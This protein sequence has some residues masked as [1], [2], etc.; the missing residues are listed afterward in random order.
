[1]GLAQ[2]LPD[3]SGLD[4]GPFGSHL[5]TLGGGVLNG[6]GG[7]A[8]EESFVLPSGLKIENGKPTGVLD[9]F[10]I[11]TPKSVV[12]SG[13][14]AS[15]GGSTPTSSAASG[16]GAGVPTYEYLVDE[17]GEDDYCEEL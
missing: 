11:A 12:G 16:Y 6:E 7:G 8:P 9:A 17:S 1:M 14:V 4:D 13:S 2:R 3:C 15:S 10:Q 5:G